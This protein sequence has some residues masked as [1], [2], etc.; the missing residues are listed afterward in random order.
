MIAKDNREQPNP[1]PEKGMLHGISPHELL[2]LAPK[3]KPYLRRSNPAWPEIVDA[4]HA[5][6]HD[7]GV[8]QCLWGYTCIAMGRQLAAVALA[9]LSTKD[10]EHFSSAPNEYFH[11]MVTRHVAGE[12]HLGRTLWALRR[13]ARH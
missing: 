3:L 4:A 13:A 12:P 7:L 9:I 10:L 5:L 11:H 2:R 1:Q 6:S 8:S